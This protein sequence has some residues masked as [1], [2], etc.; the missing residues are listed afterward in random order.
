MRVFWFP[1]V[2]IL[3]CS[4]ALG[5]ET[6]FRPSVRLAQQGDLIYLLLPDR[7]CNGNPGNDTGNAPAND[8]K[9]SGFDPANSDFFHGGDLQGIDTKLDYLSH[10]G[11]NSIWLT[12]IFKNRTVQNYGE[13]AAPKRDIMATG[14]LISQMSIRIS[15]RKRIYNVWSTTPMRTRLEQF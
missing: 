1:F 10:L 6:F 5:Q 13:G 7:F 4:V 2:F 8:P 14:F 9:V 11:V 3:G 15:E 12:P